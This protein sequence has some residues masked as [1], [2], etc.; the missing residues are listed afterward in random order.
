MTDGLVRMSVHQQQHGY[1]AGHQLLGSSVTLA[2]RDQE[3]VDRLSDM[4]GSL[5][6]GEQCPPYLTGYPLPS[7]AAY[8][9][10]RT[11][12][13]DRAPRAGCVV[14][15]SLLV[16]MDDWASLP[17]PAA[18]IR[19]F[20]RFDKARGRRLL[21][22]LPLTQPS[23]TF[24]PPVVA[25]E[26]TSVIEALFLEQRAPIVWFDCPDSEN[27]LLRIV[28]VLWPSLRR[29]FSFCTY[30][31]QPRSLEGRDFDF[32]CTPRGARPR[33]AD[34]PGRRIDRFPRHAPRHRWSER[35]ATAVF[36]S[37]HPSLMVEDPLALLERDRGG[38]AA[39]L[40][41][42][43]LWNELRERTEES[44]SAL[45]AMMDVLAAAGLPA[46]EIATRTEPIVLEATQ[47]AST[48]SPHEGFEF[49]RIL[50][51]KVTNRTSRAAANAVRDAAFKLTLLDALAGSNAAIEPQRSQLSRAFS[52][53]IGDALVAER[54]ATVLTL[55]GESERDETT[56]L[57]L[58]S[59]PTF[60]SVAVSL[61][62]DGRTR[63]PI[64][65]LV[66][67]I[68]KASAQQRRRLASVLLPLMTGPQHQ[69]LIEPLMRDASPFR[70]RWGLKALA[71]CGG[72]REPV[73]ARAFV[74]AIGRELIGVVRS[75]ILALGNSASEQLSLLELTIRQDD[76]DL[77]WILSEDKID[78]VARPQL[79]ARYIDQIPEASLGR[80]VCRQRELVDQ[81]IHLLLADSARDHSIRVARLL[82]ES[83]L[84]PPLLLSAARNLMSL[85]SSAGSS[86]VVALLPRV[87]T[88]LPL[89]GVDALRDF[90]QAESVA[91]A[92]ASL[93]G[94]RA[95]DCFVPWRPPAGG[96]QSTALA[97]LV[98]AHPEVRRVVVERFDEVVRRLERRP[99]GD[100]TSEGYAAWA[101][102][103]NECVS[104]RSRLGLAAASAT[105]EYAFRRPHLP[106]S[107]LVI[108]AFH[109]M[110]EAASSGDGSYEVSRLVSYWD[111]DKAKA[112]RKKLIE[113]FSGSGWPAGDLVVAAEGAGIARKILKRLARKSWS[114]HYLAHVRRDL[115]GRTDPAALLAARRLAEWDANPDWSE[116]D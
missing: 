60:A 7:G 83:G 58:A 100:L 115:A 22:E 96:A 48:M 53:G 16:D 6:P 94:G 3:A 98:G 66:A 10:A 69:P 19:L 63:L 111:W 82:P 4:A 92:V 112:L 85:S 45:L 49:L 80:L 42:T 65:R 35:L 91:N 51:A 29:S 52:R 23:D 31:L 37:P 116:W 14:T 106:V 46:K 87:A 90:L 93:G 18:L 95:I 97:A 101:Q 104:R 50:I 78:A 108:S 62:L 38:D 34:W 13:D 28:Q 64:S 56:S 1:V 40:R 70:V 114:E 8:V 59:S 32:L 43:V 99:F 88:D 71:R 47:R 9:I 61:D 54:N 76:I 67:I 41:L 26:Q 25:P 33:F 57:L 84:A 30:A 105:L 77:A 55:L 103:L 5:G 74:E 44:P 36:E 72:L 11:W 113:V 81:S 75:A 73:L 27:A 68:S 24:V 89:A 107:S 86:L 12:Y 15:H 2:L 39:A 102:L 21:E 20:N 109:V 17:V 110:H 79:L